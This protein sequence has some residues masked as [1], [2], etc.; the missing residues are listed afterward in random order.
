MWQPFRIQ[1]YGLTLRLLNSNYG[2][3]DW[4]AEK[5]VEFE[6]YHT[7][8]YCVDCFCV[9]GNN[10]VADQAAVVCLLVSGWW[11]TTMGF[12]YLFYSDPS[13]VQCVSVVLRICIWAIQIFL[14]VWEE[15][16]Q[17]NF[18]RSKGIKTKKVVQHEQPFSLLLIGKSIPQSHQPVKSHYYRV[19]PLHHP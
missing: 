17:T 5:S 12:H 3:V 1:P 19:L 16:F 11:Q 10:R 2:T 9:Y 7:G 4:K 6:K 18:S 15:V 8:N 14:G 13:R